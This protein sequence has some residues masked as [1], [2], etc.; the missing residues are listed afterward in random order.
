MALDNAQREPTAKVHGVYQVSQ[1]DNE[2]RQQLYQLFFFGNADRDT[3]NEV[4]QFI[5]RCLPLVLFE[6]SL[7]HLDEKF[8]MADFTQEM[9]EQPQK[10]GRSHTTRPSYLL[11]VAESSSEEFSAPVDY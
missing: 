2:L 10:T 1:T 8:S 7:D 6:L 9:P 11:M 5:E 3:S 4:D